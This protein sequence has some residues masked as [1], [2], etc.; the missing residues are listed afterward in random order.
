[1]RLVLVI[2]IGAFV[3]VIAQVGFGIYRR[4]F[5][6]QPLVVG[7]AHYGGGILAGM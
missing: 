6:D 2:I 7:I 5:S 3:T 1:M 4:F